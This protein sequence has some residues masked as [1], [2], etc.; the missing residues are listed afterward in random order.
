[1]ATITRPF[2]LREKAL[3][4]MRSWELYRANR[5][6]PLSDLVDQLEKAGEAYRDGLGTLDLDS[7]ARGEARDGAEHGDAVV[8]ARVE[9]AAT[10]AGGNA[11]D[12]EPVPGGADVP[13]QRPEPVDDGLDPVR[14]LRPQLGGAAHHALAARVHRGEGEERQLVDEARHL[15]GLD[16]GADEPRGPDVEVAGRLAADPAP[17]EDRE[18]RAH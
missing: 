1:M 6:T 15:R 9:H 7:L 14:L 11:L 13:T 17:V 4:G 3:A 18:A 2:S 5:S 8:V 16:R 12:D 10:Q